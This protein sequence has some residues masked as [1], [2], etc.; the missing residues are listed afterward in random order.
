[1]ALSNPR[2][3]LYF[4]A[5]AWTTSLIVVVIAGYYTYQWYSAPV[6]P[7]ANT[8]T[9][10]G[11]GKKGEAFGGRAIPVEALPAEVGDIIIQLS[12]LGTVT[13][14]KTVTVKGRVAGQLLRVHF[15]EGQLVR[16]GQL[17]AEIDPR[18]FKVQLAQAEGQMAR[19]RAL[20]DNARID[21]AR[22]QTLFA[23][24]SIAKQQVDTQLALVRQYEGSLAI[25]QSQI[26]SAN[27]QITYS[28][29]TAPITGR[30]GLRQIDQG[31][32]V[33]GN[34]P[35]GLVVLTQLQPISVVFSV[36]Q[37]NLPTVMNRVRSGEKLTVEAWD[38]EQKVNL[39]MG[40]LA[41]VDNQI[42]SA[43]G[44]VKLK[45]QFPNADASLF[46]NQF[47]NARLQLDTLKNAILISSAAL[48]RGA[49]GTFVYV[50][51]PDNTVTVRTISLGPTEAQRVA[52]SQGIEA[53]ELVVTDGMDRLREGALVEV[54]KR[55]ELKGSPDGKRPAEGRK[56]RPPSDA[57]AAPSAGTPAAP[58]QPANDAAKGESRREAWKRKGGEG[59]T[60]EGRPE[61]SPRKP[62]V[63]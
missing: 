27:L 15:G 38:R 46:P 31:N 22:Y 25:N 11:K 56:K 29:I 26:D 60:G 1:M 36:P 51:K 49:Q 41:S 43:T 33:S 59:G 39:A 10:G 28:R 7:A 53:G 4:R 35:N 13:P 42:D 40:R 2:S 58:A 5:A 20:L 34:E 50:V 57:Q 47:V 32:M 6:E 48:Q 18:P 8:A 12:G 52:V 17:L 24:D 44:T 23:Q 37:D 9:K 45:A 14:L 61:R 63:E 16:E 3:R 30:A 54:T 21:L 55:P 62:V 19:D